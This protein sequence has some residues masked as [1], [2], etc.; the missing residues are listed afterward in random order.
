M[1]SAR[2]GVGRAAATTRMLYSSSSW[3]RSVRSTSEGR[4]L[5]AALASRS[6]HA[7]AAVFAPKE[8]TVRDALNSALV[9]VPLSNAL[10]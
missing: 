8:M 4:N 3:A 5:G 7:S 6:F 9:S 2:M 1:V 10:Y